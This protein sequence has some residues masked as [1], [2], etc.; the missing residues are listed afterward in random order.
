MRRARVEMIYHLRCA[1]CASAHRNLGRA[2]WRLQRQIKIDVALLPAPASAAPMQ[3]QDFELHC[4]IQHMQ[5]T[6]GAHA[7]LQTLME[8]M[9]D[10]ATAT[11]SHQDVWDLAARVGVEPTAAPLITAETATAVQ[12]ALTRVTLLNPTQVPAYLIDDEYMLHGNASPAFL[13]DVLQ[14]LAEP[15]RASAGLWMA[16]SKWTS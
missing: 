10:G 16:L 4:L 5:R 15:P 1:N 8:A 7:P 13:H 14:T 12:D 6:G 9:V 3:E 11:S 2:V